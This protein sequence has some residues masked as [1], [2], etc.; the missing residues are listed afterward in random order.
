MDKAQ[1]ALEKYLAKRYSL[2]QIPSTLRTKLYFA[3]ND[4]NIKVEPTH[5]LTLFQLFEPK[6][7]KI[8]LE[9]VAK[10]KNIQGSNL[11]LYDL[12]IVLSYYPRYI[13]KIKQHEKAAKEYKG[14]EESV[15]MIKNVKNT[16]CE[17]KT[18]DVSNIVD[19]LF[20]L[21]GDI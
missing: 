21:D 13:S 16:L 3:Y 10:G 7:N 4:T 17:N 6:L 15:A 20:F 18:K 2:I 9:N 8:R 1:K 5:L 11:A 12:T 19:D 14:L